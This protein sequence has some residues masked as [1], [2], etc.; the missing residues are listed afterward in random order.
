[1]FLSKHTQIKTLH[2]C[3]N[4]KIENSRNKICISIS[5]IFSEQKFVNFWGVWTYV[6]IK[7]N[8]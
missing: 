7:F 4:Y 5:F 2:N 6:Y 8:M 3:Q 1:M